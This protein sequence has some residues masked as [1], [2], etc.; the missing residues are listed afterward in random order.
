MTA[1]R[2][3]GILISGRGSNMAALIDACMAPDFP[4]EISVV[5]SNRADAPGLERARSDAIA[6][7]VVDHRQFD[8]RP[9][10]EEQ[11]DRTLRD[12]GVEIV[13]NAGFMRLLTEFFV[14]KWYNRQINIHPS[15]LPAY[16]GLHTH[17]RILQDGVRITGCTVH[18]VRTEM[19]AGPII[20]QAAVPVLT[21]DTPDTLADRVLAAEH[22]VYPLALRLVA[23]GRARVVGDK[24]VLD[25]DDRATGPLYSPPITQI[26]AVPTGSRP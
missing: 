16:T 22:V 12:H 23:E 5:I 21:N 24:V 13:C 17:E 11:L 15:L 10:F 6:T 2:K 19:D 9:A 26:C 18:F 4:A 25:C 8:D 3:S 1:R 14:Q 7:A 20:A